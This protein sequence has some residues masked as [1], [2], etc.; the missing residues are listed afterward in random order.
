[1]MR[2]AVVNSTREGKMKD[3]V[4][5]ICGVVFLLVSLMH[6]F[7]LINRI[8]VSF[9]SFSIPVWW[10]FWGFTASLILAIL[11]MKALKK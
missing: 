1:M 10:S 11:I 4:L 2:Q 7:R 5:K 8:P 6:F 9:G 3:T